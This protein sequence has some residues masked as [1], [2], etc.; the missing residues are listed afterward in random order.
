MRCARCVAGVLV[1]CTPGGGRQRCVVQAGCVRAVV[2]A[3][4][5]CERAAACAAWHRLLA[6]DH[7]A[8]HPHSCTYALPPHPPAPPPPLPQKGLQ[9]LLYQQGCAQPFLAHP[10]PHPALHPPFPA[11]WPQPDAAAMAAAAV[12]AASYDAAGAFGPPLPP[13]PLHP[14]HFPG[15]AVHLGG[16]AAEFAQLAGAGPWAAGL[17]NGPAGM[18]ATVSA[19]AAAAAGVGVPG[20]GVPGPGILPA[21]A[22]PLQQGLGMANGLLH[23]IQEPQATLAGK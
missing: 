21:M 6:A 2:G 5:R 22:A 9:Q 15:P 14:A 4:R 18:A 19:A 16:P 12:A 8:D 13:P 17:M 1:E 10:Q 20:R 3:G 23:A 11:P 7:P